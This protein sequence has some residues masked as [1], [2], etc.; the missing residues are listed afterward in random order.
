M[1]N[2]LWIIYIIACLRSIRPLIYPTIVIFTPVM[3]SRIRQF[4]NRVSRFL[5]GGTRCDTPI[6]I[7]NDKPIVVHVSGKNTFRRPDGDNFQYRVE[8]DNGDA[9]VKSILWGNGQE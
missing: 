8:S 4:F 7:K 3:P 5:G 2:F 9:F 6:E 1:S